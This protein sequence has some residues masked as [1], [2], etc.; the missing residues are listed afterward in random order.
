[1]YW[2]VSIRDSVYHMITE[3]VENTVDACIQEDQEPE[4]W[5]LKRIIYKRLRRFRCSQYIRKM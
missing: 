5:N 1:M 2:M 3:Y 4:E